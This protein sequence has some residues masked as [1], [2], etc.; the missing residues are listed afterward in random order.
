MRYSLEI[1]RQRS[2]SDRVPFLP[3][4]YGTLKKTP[5]YC[6]MLLKTGINDFKIIK[7]KFKLSSQHVSLAAKVNSHKVDTFSFNYK[8]L[9]FNKFIL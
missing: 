5:R 9:T 6:E 3:K 7:H 2:L 1:D 4:G 8:Y